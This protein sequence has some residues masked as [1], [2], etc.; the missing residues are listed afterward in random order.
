MQVGVSQKEATPKK[1]QRTECVPLVS[2]CQE[3]RNG[4]A[5][6][7]RAAPQ[8]Q[9]HLSQALKEAAEVAQ[10]SIELNKEFVGRVAGLIRLGFLV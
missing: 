3:R 5:K 6:L 2:L 1:N 10:A 9:S 8:S 7:N 4:K